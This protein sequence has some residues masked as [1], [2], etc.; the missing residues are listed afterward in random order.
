MKNTR[1]KKIIMTRTTWMLA[2]LLVP[3]IALILG[4]SAP[5]VWADDDDDD[6]LEFEETWFNIEF[7]FSDQ[8]LGVRG[9]VD[10]E[11][12]KE[13]EIE[14]PN[15]RTIAKIKAKKSMKQQGFAE[16]FFES[17]EPTLEEVTIAEFLSRFP[18]GTYEFEGETIEGDE[19][20]GEADFTHVIPCGPGG[21]SA[22]GAN[23]SG[24]PI[25]IKW[26]EVTQVVDL[27]NSVYD[28]VSCID[29]EDPEYL[30]IVG[31]RVEVEWEEVLDEGTE[32][33]EEITHRF[34]ID[35][36]AD[37]FQVTVPPEFIPPGQEYQFEVLAV[38]VSGNQTITEEEETAPDAP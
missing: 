33:E 19:I 1:N 29:P 15:E 16:L 35:L 36:M 28:A 10:G 18:E 8:D 22:A 6:E 11:P 14:D 31:Y 20:E 34:G 25:I 3:V 2:I 30:Q 24:D 9:F 5:V 32:D 7:N 13:V 23:T 38:E 21:L 17:G 12:W 27:E 4:I 37:Q 26:E